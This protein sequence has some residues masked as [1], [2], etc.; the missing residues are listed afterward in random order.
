MHLFIRISFSKGNLFRND[1][2]MPNTILII[3]RGT[4]A[5]KNFIPERA[6]NW[7]DC[8]ID[9]LQNKGVVKS[10][11]S[12]RSFRQ[13]PS[14]SL[15]SLYQCPIQCNLWKSVPQSCVAD[16]RG[17]VSPHVVDN[18]FPPH[19]HFPIQTAAVSHSLHLSLDPGERV[20]SIRR[21]G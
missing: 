11:R 10:G 16:F 12:R 14:L 8:S 18:G 13:P 6:N 3:L 5:Q 19:L 17:D 15:P 4:R 21:R 9:E 20:V 1:L 2:S 7:R